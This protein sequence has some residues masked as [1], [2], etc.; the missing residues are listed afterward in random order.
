MRSAINFTVLPSVSIALAHAD[1]LIA[2]AIAA[3]HH[4]VAVLAGVARALTDALISFSHSAVLSA[5]DIATS[6]AESRA[7]THARAFTC[8]R[9]HAGPMLSAIQLAVESAVS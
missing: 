4:D 6:T 9:A 8:K 1:A 7:F 2:V 3:L 5:V